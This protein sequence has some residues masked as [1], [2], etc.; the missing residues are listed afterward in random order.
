MH[1]NILFLF[2]SLGDFQIF[3]FNT[4]QLRQ[5][6]RNELLAYDHECV[7]TRSGASPF[8]YTVCSLRQLFNILLYRKVSA[9]A[10]WTKIVI[11]IVVQPL[12]EISS[13]KECLLFMDIHIGFFFFSLFPLRVEHISLRW[14][15]PGFRR[16]WINGR[17]EAHVHLLRVRVQGSEGVKSLSGAPEDRWEPFSACPVLTDAHWVAQHARACFTHT[18]PVWGLY[19]LSFQNQAY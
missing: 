15:S 5:K 7:D 19:T 1:E 14:F 11:T 8:T 16:L 12:L 17:R 6:S 9:L 3:F 18:L 10:F 2:N 4:V 13:P